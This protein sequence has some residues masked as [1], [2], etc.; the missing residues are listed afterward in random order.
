MHSMA[1][2]A[3]T[4]KTS[5][6]VQSF[7]TRLVARFGHIGRRIET[8]ASQVKIIRFAAPRRLVGVLPDSWYRARSYCLVG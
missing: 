3:A 4:L 5:Q 1:G 7:Q 6:G 8:A 2:R